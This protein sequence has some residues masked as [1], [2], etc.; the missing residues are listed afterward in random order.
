MTKWNVR[1]YLSAIV[2]AGISALI[3]LSTTG[4][5]TS[6]AQPTQSLDVGTFSPYVQKFEQDSASY[7]AQPVQVTNLI[8]QF[9]PMDSADER[10]ICTVTGDETPVITLDEDYWNQIDENAREALIYHEM[11][12]C[13][14]RRVHQPALDAQGNPT[15]IMNPYTMAG[16]TFEEKET[17]YLDELFAPSNRGQ[18]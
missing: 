16:V 15:S 3:T 18:F 2:L 4:C 11:G 5:G 10:G 9:G 8:I 12:H 1:R 7:S 14:L 6:T 13:V 17:G